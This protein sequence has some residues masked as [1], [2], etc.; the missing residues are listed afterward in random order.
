VDH[1]HGCCRMKNPVVR[2]VR[3]RTA[4]PRVQHCTGPHRTPVCNGSR[5]PKRAAPVGGT[6]SMKGPGRCRG[7]AGR[8]S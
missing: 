6:P 5:V 3:A 8:R 1:D 2:Q 7:V 4:L